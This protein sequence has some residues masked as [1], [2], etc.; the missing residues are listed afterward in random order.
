MAL[1]YL[2]L[3]ERRFYTSSGTWPNYDRESI[4]GAVTIAIRGVVTTERIT[5]LIAHETIERD[6]RGVF[7]Q[8][9]LSREAGAVL[10]SLP[11]M[12]EAD[13]RIFLETL[14]ARL[15][16]DVAKVIEIFDD[17]VRPRNEALTRLIRNVTNIL[18]RRL[19]PDIQETY[20][21]AMA[22]A[23]K[24]ID[25][26]ALPDALCFPATVP[27]LKANRNIYGVF[28]PT[29]TDGRISNHQLLPHERRLL[30]GATYLPI[31]VKPTPMTIAYADSTHWANREEEHFSRS[32]DDADFV[33][34]WHRNPPRKPYSSA[35]VRVD[36]GNFFPDF[37]I[38]LSTFAGD[39]SRT[40]MVETKESIKDAVRKMRRAPKTYGKVVFITK[41]GDKYRLVDEH[42]QMG[43]V[44]DSNL[45][46]LRDALRQTSTF[47]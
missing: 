29:V 28:P 6:F 12:E 37:I 44:V 36:G 4:A 32:L 5:E 15:A 16:P 27:L 19:G 9:L 8:R 30:E 45:E 46:S 22:D 11:Q 23:V 31:D 10:Q 20:H 39:T 2:T 40:R 18:I 25:A 24:V 38:S 17:A 43:A 33:Y 42:G 47:T 7:D 14:S 13:K 3:G 41:D 1:A 21:R 35:V 26:A 34:W